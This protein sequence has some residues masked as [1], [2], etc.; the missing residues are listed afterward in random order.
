M[1]LTLIMALISYFMSA[2]SGNSKGRS[3]AIAATVGM[4]TYFA[5]QN[6]ETLASA[7]ESINNLF[8]SNSPAS[9]SANEG[10]AR[11]GVLVG[12]GATA[13]S[14]VSSLGSS[15]ADVLK[16][17]GPVGTAGVIVGTGAA[18]SMDWDKWLPWLAAGLGAY[19]L[20]K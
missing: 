3:A 17:W 2:K 20:L 11:D 9:S 4:G 14:A 10:V 13:G 5:T 18:S 7:N 19:L 8:S 16:S 15:A 12:A 1:W 6:S